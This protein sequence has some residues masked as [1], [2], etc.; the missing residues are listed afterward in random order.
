MHKSLNIERYSNYGG[1]LINLYGEAIPENKNDVLGLL[2]ESG[3]LV[4]R[5]LESDV[6]SFTNFVKSMS[7]RLSL[8]PARTFHS[9][10]A[11]KVDAG[12]DAVGLHCENGNSPFWPDLA[13]FFCERAASVGSF[14][15]VCDGYQVWDALPEEVRQTF[16]DKE[17]VYERLVPEDK[18]KNY[19]IHC[20]K[21]L[22]DYEAIE[23]SDLEKLKSGIGHADIRENED[24][25]IVYRFR[26]GAARP[27]LF[28]PKLAFANSI[29]GPSYNYKAPQ[30]SFED[31]K[32]FTPQLMNHIESVTKRFTVDIRW[33]SGDIV[34]IDNTRVMHG[35][36]KIEDKNRLIYNALSYI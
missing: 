26:V 12:L 8:D 33:R 21:G 9:E 22:I 5:G 29:L 32:P 35:R 17:I 30:I 28:S 7:S 11:Q 34:L 2:K 24:G 3:F 20:N 18:W 23:L 25:S 14:T 27:T 1:K 16:T 4:F 15:T 19:V 10:V 13:W 6:T 36:R 31:G